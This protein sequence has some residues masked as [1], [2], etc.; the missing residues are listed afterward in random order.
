MTKTIYTT[1]V[2]DVWKYV[3]DNK[4]DFNFQTYILLRNKLIP[5]KDKIKE[6]LIEAYLTGKRLTNEKEYAP[7]AANDIAEKWF[8]D[9]YGY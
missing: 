8:F 3:R 9:K 5:A 6:E 1:S 4:E 7:L 2:E